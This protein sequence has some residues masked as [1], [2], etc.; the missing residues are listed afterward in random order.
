VLYVNF[1]LLENKWRN[2]R[3]QNDVSDWRRLWQALPIKI[4]GCATGK[5]KLVLSYL[6]ASIT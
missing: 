4:L 6:R 5:L 1:Q 2:S 3:S